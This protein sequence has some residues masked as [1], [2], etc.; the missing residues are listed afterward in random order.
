MASCF[1]AVAHL[2]T[3]H[4]L[5]AC[6]SGQGLGASRT[7]SGRTCN[8][9]HAPVCNVY[10]HHMPTSTAQHGLGIR[11]HPHGRVHGLCAAVTQLASTPISPR[12]YISRCRNSC[13]AEFGCCQGF[14]GHV[15]QL[16]HTG[17]P[18]QHQ[19]PFHACLPLSRA[20]PVAHM[21]LMLKQLVDLSSH[22]PCTPC[23]MWVNSGWHVDGM[24]LKR[25]THLPA[26]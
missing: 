20:P 13:G 4:D 10:N 23:G 9:S 18:S 21:Q 6:E 25:V 14:Q 11:T 2:F 1:V 8:R 17:G 22:V 19:V 15:L 3:C 16:M 12:V 24:G 5:P 7:H 26:P